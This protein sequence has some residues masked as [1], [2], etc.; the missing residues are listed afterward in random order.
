MAASHCATF[1]SCSPR[2][3]TAWWA[4]TVRKTTLL[5]VLAGD[6]LGRMRAMSPS[7]RASPRSGPQSVEAL[8][9]DVL[10]LRAEHGGLAAELEGRLALDE[11]E[12]ELMAIALL[13]ERKR[14]QIAAALAREPDVLLHEPTNDLDVRARA[15]LTSALERFRGIAVVVLYYCELLER[16]PRAILRVHGNTVTVHAGSYLTARAAWEEAR[17]GEEEVHVRAK[18]TVHAVARKLEAA[19]RTQE[20]TER[21]VAT[22]SRMKGR[23]DHDAKS[24]GSKVVTRWAEARAGRSVH[25]ARDELV[26][27]ARR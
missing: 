11:D 14:W 12:L 4:R 21:S 7:A 18:A 23:H 10:A 17:R 1:R 25:V 24:M 20:A 19:R 26:G 9:D 5:R 15:R 2:A 13:G 22:R 6:I 8:G 16:L 3:F 27:R